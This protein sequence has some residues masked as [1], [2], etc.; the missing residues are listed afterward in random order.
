MYILLCLDDQ[1]EVSGLPVNMRLSYNYSGLERVSGE[2]SMHSVY[3][4]I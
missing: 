1:D 4:Y 2:N 3:M